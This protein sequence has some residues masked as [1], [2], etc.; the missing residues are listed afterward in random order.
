MAIE[1]YEE[2]D[3]NISEFSDDS[4][5]DNEIE[6]SFD[7]LKLS[8]QEKPILN[9]YLSGKYTPRDIWTIRD[10]IPVKERNKEQK[11]LVRFDDI[12][13]MQL[14]AKKLNSNPTLPFG[15]NTN[16]VDKPP[17]TTIPLCQ[18]LRKGGDVRE[19]IYCLTE[20]EKKNIARR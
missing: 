10:T 16:P 17:Y 13:I 5:E 3:E 7:K 8:S 6:F 19:D 12:V 11:L 15:I 1:E 14:R 2:S 18:P 20:K 9:D 4:E